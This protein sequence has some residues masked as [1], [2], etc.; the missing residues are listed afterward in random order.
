MPAMTAGQVAP[1]GVHSG[2]AGGLRRWYTIRREPI[3]GEMADA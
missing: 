2:L 1:R 3:Q